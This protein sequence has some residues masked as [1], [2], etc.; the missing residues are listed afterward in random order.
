MSIS[1][2]AF[3]VE[4]ECHLPHGKNRAAVAAAITAAGIECRAEGYNHTTGQRWKIVHD[5]SIATDE[6]GGEVVSP[7]LYGDDGYRQVEIVMNAMVAAGCTVSKQCG[8]HVHVDSTG[9][10]LGYYKDVAKLFAAYESVIDSVMPVSRR[11]NN[12]KY[13]RSITHASREEIDAASSQHALAVILG[14]GAMHSRFVKLNLWRRPAAHN[15]SAIQTVEFRQHSGTLEPVKAINWI[16]LCQRICDKAKSGITFNA[17]ATVRQIMP[18][19]RRG[20]KRA[21]CVDM[22]LRPEGAT[23]EQLLAATGWPTISV[24]DVVSRTGMELQSTRMGRRI[25][26]RLNQAA[27]QAHS[28]SSAASPAMDI[29]IAG[30]CALVGATEQ[31]QAFFEGRAAEQRRRDQRLA[32]A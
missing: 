25:T 7:K 14:R 22:L 16:K 2:R 29:S 19:V 30:L 4:I 32:A 10:S 27:A 31:E 20:S 18:K 12:N 5:G 28:L 21:I 6:T 23:R 9:E 17:A 26:Y 15:V 13:C 3:G 1:N 24:Q 8:L 11:V